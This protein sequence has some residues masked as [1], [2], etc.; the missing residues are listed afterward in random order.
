M[1]S[2]FLGFG[3]DRLFEISQLAPKRAV[4]LVFAP[5]LITGRDQLARQSLVLEVFRGVSRYEVEVVSMHLV[6]LMS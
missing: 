6:G 2:G 4:Q 5:A 3:H 1:Q